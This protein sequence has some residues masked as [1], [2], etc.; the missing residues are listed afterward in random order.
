[1]PASE[2]V[3]LWH[4]HQFAFQIKPENIDSPGYSKSFGSFCT[5]LHDC[6]FQFQ[7]MAV[8]EDLDKLHSKGQSKQAMENAKE[9]E[10]KRISRCYHILKNILDQKD[11]SNQFQNDEEVIFQTRIKPYIDEILK[12]A[13]YEKNLAIE[14]VYE[15]CSAMKSLC[16]RLLEVLR[17]LKIP[18]M[19]PRV[20][21]LTD[22]G[23]GVGISKFE[24]KFRDA[25]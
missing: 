17:V 3:R 18:V 13:Q 15:S 7:D 5:T 20:A 24:V 9:Y 10:G 2:S 22:A 1:M 4:S 21:I 16:E 19:R 11:V 23:L 14:K 6:T 12:E 8:D 25:E